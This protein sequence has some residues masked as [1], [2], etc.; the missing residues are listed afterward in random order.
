MFRL[1]HFLISLMMFAAF[2]WFA[3]TVP[4]GKRTLWGHAQAIFHTQAAKD[5]AD[6]TKEEAQKVAERVREGMHAPDM[7]PPARPRV[8]EPL[9][10]VDGKE[11]RKRD[12]LVKQ[13][14]H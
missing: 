9:D 3:V 11:R 12:H 7:S 6:G 1:V 4:L 13:R 5:L 8:V 2:I 14:T 10:P